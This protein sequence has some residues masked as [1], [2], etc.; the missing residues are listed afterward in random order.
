MRASGN[1]LLIAFVIQWKEART[2]AG[3]DC[4][5]GNFEKRGG[6]MHCYVRVNKWIN[7]IGE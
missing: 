1:Y 4:E 3:N 5:G 7:M 2:A 6:G